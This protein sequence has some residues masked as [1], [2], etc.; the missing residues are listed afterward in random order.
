MPGDEVVS[1]R[2][3]RVTVV[4]PTYNER[5]N[6][7][8]LL[9][10]LRLFGFRVLVIDDGSPDGTGQVADGLA[11]ADPMIQVLHRPAK[12]GLG[13]AYAAGFDRALQGGPD[14]VVEMDADLS[15]N[16][17]DLPRLLEA[18]ERG[19]DLA[20]GSRYVP[21]GAVP[22]WPAS[23]RLLSR[24]GNLYARL[25]LGLRVADAT[26][27]YRAFRA[28]ALRRLPYASAEA[29]GYGF[30]VE[31]VWRAEQAGLRIV[32][33]PI[34][35]RDREAGSSKMDSRVVA[36]AMRLVTVWGLGR[37]STGLPWRRS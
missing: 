23:R 16:P 21:G 27:G 30:Q 25:M 11:A 8:H 4:V 5:D 32:E 3:D 33:V 2:P 36:E 15:H 18:L 34:T 1:R 17:A 7:P 9:A 24:G 22:D 14:V 37:M 6:I 19:A 28:V 10:S 26:S 12:E 20:I 29:S 31:M 35:F 13:R